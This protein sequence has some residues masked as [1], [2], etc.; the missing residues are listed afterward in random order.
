MLKTFLQLLGEDAPV[1]RRYAWMAV[2]HGL[3]CGL[4][5]TALAP[6]LSRLLAGDLGGARAGWPCCWPA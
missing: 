1:F 4:T 6:L 5:I 2:A 3:L